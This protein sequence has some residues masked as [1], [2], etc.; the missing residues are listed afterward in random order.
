MALTQDF[1]S[2]AVTSPLGK[3][4]LLF[5]RM[6]GREALGRLFEYEL[7]VFSRNPDIKAD[8]LL[9]QP[10]TIEMTRSDGGIRHFNGFTARFS[11]IG[12]EGDLTRYRLLL[13]PWLWFLT[14]TTDCR[15]FQHKKAPDIIKQIFKEL[16]FGD[17]KDSLTGAYRE[18]DYC[19]QYRESDFNFLS[20]LM[21]EEGIH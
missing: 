7:E 11:H 1:R 6:Q 21:E 4:V 10:V 13:R 15:I 9:G 16:G 12:M 8:A 20:R 5:S 2:I 17:V 14:R 3:D 18:R 19:V